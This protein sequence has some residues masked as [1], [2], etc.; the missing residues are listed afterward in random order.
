MRIPARDA[1]AHV[2]GKGLQDRDAGGH[3]PNVDFEDARHGVRD[4]D[5]GQI[6]GFNLPGCCCA[7]DG[8][9]AG[10][11]AQA[12]EGAEGDFEAGFYV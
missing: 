10:D 2:P 9:G 7:G 1:R 3:V 5:P 8:D 4:P 11:D 6:V 12:H